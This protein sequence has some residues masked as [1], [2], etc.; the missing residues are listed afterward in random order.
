MP[1]TSPNQVVVTKLEAHNNWLYSTAPEEWRPVL[2]KKSD[3]LQKL[4][5]WLEGKEFLPPREDIWNALRLTGPDN[6]RVVILGQD[7]YPTPGHAHGLAFSVKDGVGIAPSLRNIF[8]ELESDVGVKHTGGCLEDWAVQGVLMLNTI[9]S[10]EPGKPQSH[11]KIGWEEV[12]D[13]ILRSLRGRKIVFVLWG[14]VAQ[15]KKKLLE[16]ETIWESA[17][18]SPLS[19]HNGFFGSKPFSAINRLIGENGLGEPIRWS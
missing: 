19:A 16:G 4:C 5:E 1:K 18:P 13:E 17:H 9:L 2:A 7:P 15:A 14:K 12:T 8:K 6:V 11:A 3:S 10:V